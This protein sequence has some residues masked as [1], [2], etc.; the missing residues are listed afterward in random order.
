MKNAKLLLLLVVILIGVIPLFFSQQSQAAVGAAGWGTPSNPINAHPGYKDVP[1]FVIVSA[2]ITLQPQQAVLDLPGEVLSSQCTT[3]AYGSSSQ[4][5]LGSYVLTFDLSVP[6]STSPGYYQGYLTVYYVNLT[7]G[8]TVV[9]SSPVTIPVKPVIYPTLQAVWGTSSSPTFPRAGEG[10][11]PLTLVVENPSEHPILDV[12]VNVTLPKGVFSLTG[13]KYVCEEASAIPAG[14][15]IPITVPVNVSALSSPGVYTMSYSI[16][17]TNYLEFQYSHQGEVNTSIYSLSPFNVTLEQGKAY[18]GSL[19]HFF[20]KLNSST[21]GVLLSMIPDLKVVYTNFT[22]TPLSPGEE[23]TFCYEVVTPETVTGTYPVLFRA[24]L[25]DMGEIENLTF[26]KPL[27]IVN[28]QTPSVV[29]S[30]WGGN[31]SLAFPEEGAALLTLVVEN[32]LPIPLENVNLTLIPPHGISPVYPY[33]DIPEVGNFSVREVSYPVQIGNVSAGP[34]TFRYVMSYEGGEANGTFTAVISQISPVFAEPMTKPIPVGGYSNLTVYVVN[35][36][37]IPVQDVGAILEVEG[38]Q[39]IAYFNQTTLSISPHSNSSF[40]FYLYAPPNLNT[41]VYP[42]LLKVFFSEYSRTLNETYV[43]PLVVVQDPSISVSLSPTTVFYSSNNT[44][45]LSLT[46]PLPSPVYD[47]H[48]SLSSQSPLYISSP[49][50]TVAEIPP[51]TTSSFVEYVIPEVPS[52]STIPLEMD[53][54]YVYHGLPYNQVSLVELFSTGNVSLSMT[55]V[56]SSVVNG[57]VVISGTLVDE[58]NYPAKGVVVSVGNYTSVYIGDV[59]PDTPTPFSVSFTVPPG[60]YHFNVTATYL[61]SVMQE[62][63]VSY[64]I[65]MGVSYNTSTADSKHVDFL[66]IGIAAVIVVLVF[67]IIYLSVRRK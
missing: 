66:G 22:E 23:R 58:G 41:G 51:N 26:L 2:P 60:F 10:V 32:P 53:T 1:F 24:T 17:F 31:Q 7:S 62:K 43:V 5:S 18:A 6:S 37:S 64:S 29:D 55:G 27:N 42:S 48:V 67:L 20:V 4:S 39:E 36:G 54:S 47:V 16:S 59:S 13:E 50:V 8:K 61:N 44:V 33:V 28:N 21:T 46:N 65:S 57:S 40:V 3:V 14:E 34:V 15:T 49:S 9:E 45:L 12:K 63:N 38:V 11:T 35:N 19:T 56:S 30:F 25:D 52:T